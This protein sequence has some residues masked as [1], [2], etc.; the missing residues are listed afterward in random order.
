MKN[1]VTPAVVDR[2]LE[3]DMYQKVCIQ[4]Q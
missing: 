2:H 4:L 1:P 3:L